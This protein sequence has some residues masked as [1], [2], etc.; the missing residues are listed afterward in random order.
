M[1]LRGDMD[2]LPLTE[3]FESDFQSRHEGVMHAC[4]HDTHVATLA[5]AARLLSE[6]ALE[7]T[8]E[9]ISAFKKIKRAWDEWGQSK[10]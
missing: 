2:A 6:K 4:G 1:L 5:S 7:F 10:G 8:P 3:D 9:A